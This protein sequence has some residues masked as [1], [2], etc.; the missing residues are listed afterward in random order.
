M[1]GV[2]IVAVTASEAVDRRAL[3][4]PVKWIAWVIV[5]IYFW[6][7]IP[8]AIYMHATDPYLGSLDSS[9]ATS[10]HTAEGQRVKRMD[11]PTYAQEC[12]NTFPLV[13]LA[14]WRYGSEAAAYYINACIVYFCI[15][16]AN[17][18]LYVA[19]RTLYGLA[20]P[21]TP[22][23]ERPQKWWQQII[24][25]RYLLGQV[26]P[27][28]IPTWALL[29]SAVSWVWLIAIRAADD[30]VDVSIPPSK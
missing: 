19:S 17:T 7:A 6:V 22:P 13:V 9:K 4:K 26:A 20:R 11:P 8:G 15:S 28:G 2:E 10:P 3:R 16:S 18:A 30:G 25:S 5:F 14:A 1:L 21:I 24:P 27:N 12:Q 23:Q 29:A